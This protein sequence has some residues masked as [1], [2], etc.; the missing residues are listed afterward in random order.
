[1][2]VSDIIG[3]YHKATGPKRWAL[4]LVLSVLAFVFM[5]YYYWRASR[6]YKELAR[7]R[8]E[9]ELKT[10]ALEDARYK[11]QVAGKENDLKDLIKEYD[12]ISKDIRQ[13]NLIVNKATE[14]VK[15]AIQDMGMLK[16]W[17][18]L[19]AYNQRGRP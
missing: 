4:W 3:N 12:D 14:K 15:A 10:I 16:T 11:I 7:V 13:Q 17:D 5:F 1:M 19:D 6:S 9:F 2:Q 18:D 8:S